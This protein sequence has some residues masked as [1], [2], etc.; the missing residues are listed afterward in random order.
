MNEGVT[1][2][3]R[4]SFSSVPLGDGL[5]LRWVVPEVAA[6]RRGALDWDDVRGGLRRELASREPRA[7]LGG[8]SCI[9][10]HDGRVGRSLRAPASADA[11][12]RTRAA[13]PPGGA[14]SA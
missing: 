7:P 5:T 9:A 13:G 11:P 4:N 8:E 2:L 10:S 6:I 1:G 3:I 12:L 14:S